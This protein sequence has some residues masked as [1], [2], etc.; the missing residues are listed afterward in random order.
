M[1]MKS[2]LSI[3]KNKVSMGKEIWKPVVGYESIYE[4]SSNGRVR[5]L[6]RYVKNPIHGKILVKGRE[7]SIGRSV[8]YPSVNIS[9]EGKHRH[10]KVHVLIAQAFLNHKPNGDNT[11]VVD[12]IDNNKQNNEL[13]NL[14]LIT[15]RKNSTKD[16]NNKKYSKHPGVTF[17]LG[18]MKWKSTIIIKGTTVYLGY[19]LREEEAAKSYLAAI[20]KMNLFNGN[21]IE[22]R[23]IIKNSI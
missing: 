16:R 15:N 14:Q 5:S 4:V 9:K 7:M 17:S 2:A 22:F 18:N 20:E 12:H 11:I 13:S 1:L 19:F 23:K 6:D 8:G 10:I 3:R 21:K